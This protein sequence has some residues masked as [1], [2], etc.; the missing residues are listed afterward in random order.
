MKVV[1]QEEMSRLEV[2][3]EKQGTRTAELMQTAGKRVAAFTADFIEAN[4]LSKKVYLLVGKGNNGGDALVAGIE[5]FSRGFEVVAIVAD[6]NETHSPLASAAK[7]EF[8]KKGGKVYPFALIRSHIPEEGVILDG[9]FG[10][11][12]HGQI[13]GVYQE[14]IEYAN[15]SGLP[16]LAIDIASGVGGEG[17]PIEASVTLAIGF[18]KSPS[19]LGE[20]WDY[21]GIIQTLPLFSE[22]VQEAAKALFSSVEQEELTHLL[23]HIQRSRHK[24]ERGFVAVIAGSPGMTGAAYLSSLGAFRGGAGI[25]H[26]YTPRELAPFFANLPELI[27][28]PIDQLSTLEKYDAVVIGPGLGRGDKEGDLVEEVLASAK[29]VVIDGDALYHLAE[30]RL[31]LP[32]AAVL[33]PHQGELNRLLGEEYKKRSDEWLKVCSH[34]ASK[35]KVTLL[36]KGGPTFLFAEETRVIPFGDPGMATA[37]CGDL[38]SGMIGAL[39]AQGLSSAS[40]ALLGASL[41]GIAGELAAEKVTSYSMTVEDI[42]EQIPNAFKQLIV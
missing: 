10:T 31:L 30:R 24:Y 16:I 42:A 2:V 37:G 33:T 8:L 7:T 25:V 19:Y 40:A 18:P 4:C 32:P 14:I 22:E 12:F 3:A 1:T 11:G 21:S 27:V 38:L 29:Q 20:G 17:H 26:L 36:A 9:I 39:L 13:R 6:T 15:H 35:R 5:L 23:P 28:K 41:H 34:Y